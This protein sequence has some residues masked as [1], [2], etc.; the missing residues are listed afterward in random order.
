M[1]AEMKA[2]YQLTK[3]RPGDVW[4]DIPN[5]ATWT[6]DACRQDVTGL[7]QVRAFD[8]LASRYIETD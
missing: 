5:S 2:N 1:R 4:V 8:T 3:L 7:L 6:P